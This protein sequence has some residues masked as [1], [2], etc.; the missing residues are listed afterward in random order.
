MASTVPSDRLFFPA[1][2]GLE[3]ARARWIAECGRAAPYADL[4]ADVRRLARSATQWLR[5]A[6]ASDTG[7]RIAPD[8]QIQVL[9]SLFFRNK[10]AYIVG[11]LINQSATFPFAIAQLGRAHV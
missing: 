5:R 3:P 2:Q 6:I 1:S 4:P 7:Q 11:R 9:N 8:C 10:G